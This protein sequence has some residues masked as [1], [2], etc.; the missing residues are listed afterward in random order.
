[1]VSN[2]SGEWL[3]S[4]MT[5]IKNRLWITMIQSWLSGHNILSNERDILRLLKFSQMVEK[6]AATKSRRI[7]IW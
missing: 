6:F 7:L 3:F 5:L 4:K 2:S 1:M